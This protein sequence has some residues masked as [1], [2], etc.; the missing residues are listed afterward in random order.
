[1]DGH[2]Q[3]CVWL[4]DWGRPFDPFREADIPDTSLSVDERNVGGLGLHLIKHVSNHYIYSGS[5]GS[6]TVELY[7]KADADH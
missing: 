6:N 3:F 5:D 2:D 7:F 4:K 1:M